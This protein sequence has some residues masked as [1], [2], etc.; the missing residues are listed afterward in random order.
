MLI[1]PA[2][3]DHGVEGGAILVAETMMSP[4]RDNAAGSIA[5]E[6]AIRFAPKKRAQDTDPSTFEALLWAIPWKKTSADMTTACSAAS[7]NNSKHI[8]VMGAVVWSGT[9]QPGFSTLTD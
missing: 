4:R 2:G 7:G 5:G 8:S 6:F 3:R 1:G 9:S